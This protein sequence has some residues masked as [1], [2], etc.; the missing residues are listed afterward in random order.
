MVS[1]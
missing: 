1:W